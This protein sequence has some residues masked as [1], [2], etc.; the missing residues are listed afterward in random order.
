MIESRFKAGQT[1]SCTQLKQFYF[2]RSLRNDGALRVF[3]LSETGLRTNLED[4]LFETDTLVFG[5]LCRVGN[6]LPEGAPY[7]D[8]G[9]GRSFRGTVVAFCWQSVFFNPSNW[10]AW[11][12]EQA[13][14][15][16]EVVLR[17]VAQLEELAMEAL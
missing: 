15:S 11:D 7:I 5:S 4:Y 17:R 13:P 10:V 6:V 14:S 8:V 9:N 2:V 3:K 12:P 1:V 16:S